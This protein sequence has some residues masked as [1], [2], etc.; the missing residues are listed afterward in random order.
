M[1]LRVDPI[2]L[3]IGQPPGSSHVFNERQQLPAK[4]DFKLLSFLSV[5]TKQQSLQIKVLLESDVY[6]A[7]PRAA[8]QFVI[9]MI[10]HALH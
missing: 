10:R 3:G 8:R 9:L 7:Y 6:S 2:E 4:A 1:C 5:G